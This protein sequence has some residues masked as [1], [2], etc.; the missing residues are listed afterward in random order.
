MCVH[1][2]DLLCTSYC[3]CMY[4]CMCVHVVYVLVSVHVYMCVL[5]GKYTCMYMNVE[6]RGLVSFL[7]QSSSVSFEVSSLIEPEA[8]HTQNE[9]L[10]N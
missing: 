8:E 6:A 5:T 7:S 4:P 1:V 2:C 10:L 9:M 3:D